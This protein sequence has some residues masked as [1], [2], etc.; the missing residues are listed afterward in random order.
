MLDP[1]IIQESI[2]RRPRGQ[3]GGKRQKRRVASFQ[4]RIRLPS[5]HSKYLPLS[6]VQ[7]CTA[8]AGFIV[9]PGTLELLSPSEQQDRARQRSAV[10]PITT[11]WWTDP[12]DTAAPKGVASDSARPKPSRQKQQLHHSLSELAQ[13]PRSQARVAVEYLE[14]LQSDRD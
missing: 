10:A 11:T 1:Q 7:S 14:N 12:A 4:E 8:L 5:P 13:R 3:P 2:P 6:S 9:V